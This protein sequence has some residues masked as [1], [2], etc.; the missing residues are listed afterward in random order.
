MNKNT[1][2]AR[3]F[4]EIYKM[5]YKKEV[6]EAAIEDILPLAEHLEKNL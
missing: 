3:C 4:S 2:K 1:I 5:L 6:W